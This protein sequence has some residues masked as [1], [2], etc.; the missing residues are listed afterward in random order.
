MG[1]G[2]NR[3]VDSVLGGLRVGVLNVDLDGVLVRLNLNDA[4]NLDIVDAAKKGPFSN[5]LSLR[6]IKVGNSAYETISAIVG[7]GSFVGCPW[8]LKAVID[9]VPFLYIDGQHS[10]DEVESWITD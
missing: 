3:V 6:E 5:Y 7:I 8:V 1:V 10:I 4:S 9:R 2:C